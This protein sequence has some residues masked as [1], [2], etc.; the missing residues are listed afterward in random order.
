[1]TPTVKR[2][3]RELLVEGTNAYSAITFLMALGSLALPL[4]LAQKIGSCGVLVLI[5]VLIAGFSAWKTAVEQIPGRARL[6]V[7]KKAVAV[8][9][10]SLKAGRIPL[11]PLEFRIHLDAI[12]HGEQA[13][14]L[15]SVDVVAFEMGTSFLAAEPSSSDLYS[16]R[17]GHHVIQLPF[18]LKAGSANPAFARSSKLIFA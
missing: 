3:L 15:N 10:R 8:E 4:D 1:M 2:Y 9:S 12:N 6:T 11:S 16:D 14:T 7:D 5:S 18:S 17:K 13:A